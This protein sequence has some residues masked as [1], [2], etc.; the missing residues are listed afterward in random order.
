MIRLAVAILTCAIGLMLS[1]L[2]SARQVSLQ[3][4]HPAHNT[5]ELS[6]SAQEAAETALFDSA[7]EISLERIF[8][9]CSNCP[10]RKVVLRRDASKRFENATV[11]QTD[12]HSKKE[13]YGELSAYYF[14]N[15]L[16]LIE[17]QG[18][19]SMNNGYA[20]EWID[21]L[22]VNIHVSIGDKHKTIRSRSEGHVPSQLWGIY[23][24]IDGASANVKWK[25]DLNK[26]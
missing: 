2:M 19:F 14:N 11:I 9:G 10:D 1:S 15:L 6:E 22:I 26:P 7:S 21:S 20:M 23:Y 13:R 25:T 24:A 3:T 4:A 17:G 18:Y 12:L 16:K 8:D 5:V